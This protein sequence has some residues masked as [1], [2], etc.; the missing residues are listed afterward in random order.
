MPPR[1]AITVVKEFV[2]VTYH[3]YTLIMRING[4]PKTYNAMG[5]SHWAVKAKEVKYWHEQVAYRVMGKTPKTP[6]LRASVKLIRCSARAPDADGIV[7]SFKAP[8]DGLTRA[9]IIAN[10]DMSVIG[11]PEYEW[12]K[13]K[14]KS[15]YIEIYVTEN[16]DS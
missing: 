5:R 13:G 16:L 8:L 3:P 12:R 11:F 14:M 7:S 9:G 2:Q 10:D 15:G 1:K 4:L 6:L